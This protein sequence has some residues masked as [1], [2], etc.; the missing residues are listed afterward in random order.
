VPDVL[1]AY[2]DF[3]EPRSGFKGALALFDFSMRGVSI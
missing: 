2:E 1:V 3:C